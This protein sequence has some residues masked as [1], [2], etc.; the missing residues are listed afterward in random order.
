MVYIISTQPETKSKLKKSSL[1]EIFRYFSHA[2]KAKY[3]FILADRVSMKYLIIT[4]T[5]L[6]SSFNKKK[7]KTH[8][9]Q[10][11]K[12]KILYFQNTINKTEA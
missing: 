9:K 7:P 10:K 3:D 4:K 11:K 2:F 12:Q 8:S 1:N 6:K 5:K